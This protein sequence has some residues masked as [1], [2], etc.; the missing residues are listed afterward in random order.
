MWHDAL[1]LFD[2][3]MFKNIIDPGPDN[4]DDTRGARFRYKCPVATCPGNTKVPTMGFK[5]YSLHLAVFHNQLEIALA[6]CNIEGIEE[7]KEAVLHHRKLSK[8]PTVTMPQ[9]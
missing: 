7:V 2:N 9:K 6:Q 8:V 3:N 1:C 5:S 4:I